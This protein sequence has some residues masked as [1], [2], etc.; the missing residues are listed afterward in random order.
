VSAEQKKAARIDWLVDQISSLNE[1]LA[2]TDEDDEEYEARLNRELE[3]AS[4]E[5]G[6][7][8]GGALGAAEGVTEWKGNPGKDRHLDN[9]E[10]Q[11]IS[12]KS[13]LDE[14][15]I[16]GDQGN[17]KEAFDHALSSIKRAG[18]AVSEASWAGESAAIA[19]A[20]S[21]G[22]RAI[23]R[24][25]HLY[26]HGPSKNPADIPGGNMTACMAIM[27]A[28]GDVDSPGALCNW[29]SRR[30]GY[31]GSG[32]RIPRKRSG[33]QQAQRERLRRAMRGT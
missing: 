15:L 31:G 26:R 20:R 18:V 4:M 25:R 27:E 8:T 16:A 22:D 1:A 7:L 24:A 12:A 19:A 33:K 9:A 2:Y 13:Y 17:F 10:R 23:K 29:L 28:R 3:E 11:I 6:Y 14:S 32:A 5:L 30:S 21:I